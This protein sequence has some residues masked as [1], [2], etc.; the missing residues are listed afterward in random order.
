MG[1]EDLQTGRC[2]YTSTFLLVLSPPLFFRVFS[3]YQP[4]S[5]DDLEERDNISA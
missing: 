1:K 4:K 2:V 5:K 3:L